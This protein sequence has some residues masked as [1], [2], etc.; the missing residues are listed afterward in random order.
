MGRI[1]FNEDPNHFIFTR[2]CAGIEKVT[3]KDLIDF[4]LQY[5]DTQITDFMVCICASLAWYRSVRT[6]NAIDKY[7]KWVAEGKTSDNEKDPVVR[8]TKLLVDIYETEGIEMHKLWVDTLRSIGIRPWISVRMNDIHETDREDSFLFSN[9]YKTHRH[10]NRASHRVPANYYE[11]G[12]NYLYEDVRRYYMTLIEEALD[13]FDMDGLELDWMREIY[14]VGIGREYEGISVINAFMRDVFARVKEAEKKWGHPIRIGVRLPDTPE[15]CLR[16]G[17]DFFD[18]V[19]E[20]LIDLITVTPRWSSIDNNMPIDIW[21]KILAGKSV[22]L[23]AGLEI[24]IDAYNRRG[25]KYLPNTY[26][27]AIGSA[28]A[29][30]FM[31]ADAIYLFNYMDGLIPSADKDDSLYSNGEIYHKFLCTAG[32]YDKAAAEPRRHV[33]T[34]DDVYAIGAS[35]SK[36]LP[37]SLAGEKG[38]ATSFAAI[39]IVT[40]KIQKERQ[41]RVVLGFSKEKPFEIGKITVYLNAKRCVIVGRA[42]PVYPQYEDMEYYIFEAQNDGTLPPVSVLEIGISEGNTAVHWTE[43]DII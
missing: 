9:F 10:M 34:Y 30:H 36:Q 31:G 38:K 32:D 43:I 26:E 40:G 33:V 6:E 21:K 8:C 12:L 11:Y 14:S 42:E 2:A 13:T 15:K 7:K 35:N 3:K 19:E 23:A 18:W 4:I 39:R 25:R 20:G 27:T 22:E 17:F 28:C 5:K 29:Y 16:L 1:I 24:L 37:V 41:V